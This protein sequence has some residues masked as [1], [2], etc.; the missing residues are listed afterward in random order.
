[1]AAVPADLGSYAD[2][3]KVSD[4][5]RESVAALAGLKVMEGTG[6]GMLSPKNSCTVEQAILLV[7]RAA[8]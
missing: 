4:W 6:G 5:A 2:S 8:K 3:D 7:Y 1:V